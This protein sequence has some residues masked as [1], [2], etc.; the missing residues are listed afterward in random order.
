MLKIYDNE[1]EMNI[2]ACECRMSDDIMIVLGDQS[3]VD[4]NSMFDDDAY[5]KAKYFKYDDYDSAVDYVYKQI[6]Y[7]FKDSFNKHFKFDTY[8]SMDRIRKIQEDASIL[9][10]DDYKELASFSSEDEQYSCDL[11]INDGQM[12]LRYNNNGK[13]IT[14]E[15]CDV[16]LENDAT[17]MLAMK[18]KLEKF[19]NGEIEYEIS[20]DMEKNIKV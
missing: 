18:E 14:F 1:K 17:L 2:W 10:Y 16:N 20:M 12:G 13:N 8:Q 11:I 3:N 6:K 15:A 19:I 4:S 7:I 5:N 9:I